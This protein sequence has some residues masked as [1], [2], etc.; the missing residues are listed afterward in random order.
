MQC[1]KPLQIVNP[2]YKKCN[3]NPYE[4]TD[5]KDYF[6]NVPCGLCYSCIKRFQNDWRVRLLAE[7]FSLSSVQLARSRFLS[8][9]IA[10]KYY[11]IACRAPQKL[12]KHF[13]DEYRRLFKQ[14]VKYWCITEFGDT[15]DRFHFHML[16]FD[17]L[18]SRDDFDKIWKFGFVNNKPIVKERVLYCISYI[19]KSL[20]DSKNLFIDKSRKPKVFCSPG[21][22]KA[23]VT[24]STR[25]SAIPL[26]GR[27]DLSVKIG[28]YSYQLPRYLQQKIF[29]E[30]ELRQIK[31]DRLLFIQSPKPP[32]TLGKLAYNSI[33]EFVSKLHKDYS[34][35][36]PL[37]L[38]SN[39]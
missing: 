8:L 38:N 22:G 5:K 1:L 37:I 3:R 39:G 30:S 9:S 11:K 31:I 28:N 13:R 27:F 6:I 33:L 23:Y 18:A 24:S 10:P 32:Y 29:T 25:S 16:V 14:S 19:T 34:I 35:L 21:I 36:H 26:P 12:I 2:K 4:F 17:T 20:L 15:T 7:Y